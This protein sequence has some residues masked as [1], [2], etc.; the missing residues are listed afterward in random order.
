M[1]IRLLNELLCR[2]GS[3]SSPVVYDLPLRCMITGV[4]FDMD[5]LLVDSEPWWREAETNVFGALSKAPAA[6]D[7]EEMM[8]NRIEDV[9]ARWRVKHPWQGMSDDA[10]KVAIVDEVQRLVTT[11][12]QLMPG[13]ISTLELFRDKKL[14]V[15]LAS[16]SPLRLIR[17]LMLH[18]G[19]YGFF[20]V[21]CSAE[22]EDFGKP[23]PAVFLTAA[24]HLGIQPHELLVFEDSFNG[25]IAAKAARM[26]CI[27]VPAPE[28]AAQ[29][30]FAA[31]D[32]VLPSLTMFDD[33]VLR[34]F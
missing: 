29:P 22:A 34:G 15:A 20:Q 26:K 14:P 2:T 9:I 1:S 12:A 10:V 4:I 28:H 33:E 11:N 5:G 16:S 31:A 25:V 23:H 3:I 18:Y 6:S 32:L 8:G 24:K 7:F 17:G 27:A 21:V 30:R 19:V 13:V